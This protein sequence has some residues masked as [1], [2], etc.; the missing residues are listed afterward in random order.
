MYCELF[1]VSTSIAITGIT[2]TSNLKIENG[3]VE[4]KTLPQH[5]RNIPK[6]NCPILSVI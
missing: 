6:S 5:L 3:L 1:L 2:W 4:S